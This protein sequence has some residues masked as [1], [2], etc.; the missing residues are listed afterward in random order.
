MDWRGIAEI[1]TALVT[2]ITVLLP[3]LAKFLI[4]LKKL[5]ETDRRQQSDI[6]ALWKGMINRGFLGARRAGF[7]VE[8]AGKL[9]VVE[10]VRVLFSE[11]RAELKQARL[12]LISFLG[13]E[14]FDI[15]LAFEIEKRHQGWLIANICPA[16]GRENYE[17]V[18]LAV[19]IA[20]ENG[21]RDH[22]P[23][24]WKQPTESQG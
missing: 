14:P 7:L 17:C 20:R 24:S 10:K 8:D 3:M 11:K 6:D 15:E 18:A 12:F 5:R 22:Q 9:R 4:E 21:S 19:A 16:I 23:G 2:A 13:R 1:I